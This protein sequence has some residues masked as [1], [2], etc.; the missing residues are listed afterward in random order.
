MH[1]SK[2]HSSSIQHVSTSLFVELEQATLDS[3][4]FKCVFCERHFEL[5]APMAATGPVKSFEVLM[6]AL[7][8]ITGHL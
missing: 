1:M 5:S 6:E 2:I 7:L 3:R 4:Q 8:H